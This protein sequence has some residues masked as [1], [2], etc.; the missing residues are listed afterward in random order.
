MR[1]TIFSLTIVFV[2]F[3]SF[4]SLVFYSE[5]ASGNQTSPNQS[6][7]VRRK[8]SINDIF[9]KEEIDKAT[10][11]A[12][13]P[14]SKFSK[15]KKII[16]RKKKEAKDFKLP[17]DLKA[18]V[19]DLNSSK[20]LYKQNEEKKNSIASIT[21]LMTTLVFLDT[22][23]KWD[24]YYKIK[25]EDI[26]KGGRA[27]IY[28]GEEIKIKDLFFLSLIASDNTAAKALAHSTGIE[29][30]PQAM[31]KK[32]K[33]LGL[34]ST[35]FVDPVGISFLDISTAKDV[36]LL[37]KNAL[38]QEKIKDAIFRKDYNFKT[39]KGREVKVYSTDW[40]FKKQNNN[41]KH[42][43]GKTGYTESAGYCFAGVFKNNNKHD[44]ITVILNSP[45]INS[46]FK[47]SNDLASWVF[48]NYLWS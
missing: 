3:I 39:L 4:F 28:I 1:K 20:I 10:K 19:Y 26:V 6:Y 15:S 31:N 16:P 13:F 36:A 18:L 27:H 37:L 33:S 45:T 2:F 7:I 41:F 5:T 9:S 43:G 47:Y 12:N 46:R 29:D 22:D 48:K 34:L 40:L 11:Q 14:V 35:S 17:S 32:A 25:K 30:F 21:K 42:L 23:I 24:Q 44:I 8:I 38:K